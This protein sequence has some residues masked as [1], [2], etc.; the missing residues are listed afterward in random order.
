MF[1]ICFN[2]VQTRFEHHRLIPTWWFCDETHNIGSTHAPA[3]G[4]V[5]WAKRFLWQSFLRLVFLEQCVAQAEKMQNANAFCERNM[6]S[7]WRELTFPHHSRLEH[8][9]I[10]ISHRSQHEILPRNCGRAAHWPATQ[11]P[12][13][14]DGNRT[15]QNLFDAWRQIEKWIRMKNLFLPNFR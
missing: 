12:H 4:R 8:P 15:N 2:H 9:V 5:S 1:Q 11:D 13:A 10:A 7:S 3:G 6:R 14:I